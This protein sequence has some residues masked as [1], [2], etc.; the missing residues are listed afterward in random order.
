M[1]R[2]LTIPQAEKEY[3]EYLATGNEFVS[4]P[5]ITKEGKVEVA[6]VILDKTN[7]LI[8][9]R[10]NNLIEPIISVDNEI[11]NLKPIRY[12]YE[13]SWIPVF[14]YN[15]AKMKVTIRIITPKGYKGFVYGITVKNIT[16]SDIY[17]ECGV[18]GIWE[19]SA[20][21]VFHTQKICAT[22]DIF[23]HTW[24]NSIMFELKNMTVLAAMAISGDDDP[25]LYY[26]KEHMR[27]KVSNKKKLNGHEEKTFY[28]YYSVNMEQ[29]GAGTTN[30]DLRRRGGYNLYEIETRWLQEHRVKLENKLL[31]DRV[32]RNIFFSYFYS[33]AYTLDT[34]EQVLLTSKSHKYYVSAAFW[35]RDSLLWSF[36][37]VCLID[38]D[39]ARKILL[40]CFS[41]Y[42]R[43]AGIH[44]LYINGSVL[45]PGFELDELAAY[46]IALDEYI[47]WTGDNEIINI[48]KIR[49]GL[50]YILDVLHKWYSPECGLY[51]TEL[52]PSDDPVTYPYLIYDNVLVW[53]ALSFLFKYGY[54]SKDDIDN[55]ETSIKKYGIV[56]GPFGKMYAWSTDCNG[57]YEIYDDPPGSLALISYY[58]FCSSNDDV[59][60]NT[61]RWI[62]SPENKYYFRAEKFDGT[63]CIHTPYPWLMSICNYL[64][65]YKDDKKIKMIENLELDNGFACES[66]DGETGIVKTGNAFAT[67]AGFFG[68]TLAKVL[69]IK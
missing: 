64:L 24:T 37:A 14:T 58:G 59:Y 68:Y 44:S 66:F 20:S 25:D 51:R 10:G 46:V 18:Q 42:L 43:N 61:V 34:E 8:D 49:Q 13:N 55:L 12:R 2:I 63:G 52:D 28:Y 47:E 26:D 17:I 69:S 35:G 65:V 53:K 56:E 1:Q 7:S 40:T 60:I 21:T 48:K 15:G 32:N 3:N 19:E 4:I 5:S 54:A 36:P 38:K 57:N 62:Y 16:S 39:E 31:E 23:L 67:C 50:L 29:D 30:I 45:Y 11:I 27:Y 22:K 9:F 41:R 33:V 6:N